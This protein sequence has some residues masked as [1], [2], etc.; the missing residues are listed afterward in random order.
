MFDEIHSVKQTSDLTSGKQIEYLPTMAMRGTAMN[1]DSS[2]SSNQSDPSK[3]ETDDTLSIFGV[4]FRIAHLAFFLFLVNGLLIASLFFPYLGEIGHNDDSTYINYGRSMTYGHVVKYAW[5]PLAASIHALGF[6][7]FK[8]SPFW[9][10]HCASLG[11]IFNFSLLWLGMYLIARQMV[12][13]SNPIIL[14]LLLLPFPGFSILLINTTDALFTALSA[15]ALWQIISFHNS[16]RSIHLW[17]CSILVGLSALS[18]SDGLVV[19]AISI[20]I[21]FLFIIWERLSWR[22]IVAVTIPCVL[23]VSGYLIY[24]GSMSGQYSLGTKKRTY[25]AFEMGQGVDHDEDYASNEFIAGRITAR[26]LYG[27]SDENDGSVFKAISNN[28]SAFVQR[29]IDMSK[30]LPLY[31]FLTYGKIFSIFLLLTSIR[32]I[33][34]LIRRAEYLLLIII[35]LWA[36]HILV[37]SITA[38]RPEYLL[39]PCF[40]LL[41]LSSIGITSWLRGSKSYIEPIAL[42]LFCAWLVYFEFQINSNVLLIPLLLIVTFWIIW[43]LVKWRK[44]RWAISILVVVFCYNAFLDGFYHLPR[45]RDLGSKPNEKALIALRSHFEPGA[46]IVSYNKRDVLAAEMKNVPLKLGLRGIDDATDM[47]EWLDAGH[48]QGI[49]VDPFLMRF[50]PML[51]NIIKAQIGESL[52]TVYV[53]EEGGIVILTM[54][55]E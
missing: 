32:G 39:L 50:E 30:K 10:V 47:Q 9:L 20:L 40:S 3:L 13:F 48:A 19:F 29:V 16:R 18:R 55:E 11:R 51:W 33:A 31:F 23:M 35:L 17:Y 4:N 22:L 36:S 24:Q 52:E 43:Y 42:S 27:T 8:D 45:E 41:L 12:A 49:Y 1:P 53:S 14:L 2:C 46:K 54:V 25:I 15:L 6:S 26:K 34:D 37:Y 7:L 5:S 21:S 38:F 28:P 44:P